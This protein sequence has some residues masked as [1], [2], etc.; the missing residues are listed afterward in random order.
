M[1][2]VDRRAPNNISSTHRNATVRTCLKREDDGVEGEGMEK[3]CGGGERVREWS[4][5]EK[6]RGKGMKAKKRNKK[7]QEK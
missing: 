5:G 1:T 7:E 2:I 3:G 4:K 6:R